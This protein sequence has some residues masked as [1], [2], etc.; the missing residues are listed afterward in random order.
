MKR[1]ST[2]APMS[3]LTALALASGQ[4]RAQRVLIHPLNATAGE[5]PEAVGL[6]HDGKTVY[7]GLI[8]SNTLVGFDAQSLN[9]VSSVSVPASTGIVSDNSGNLFTTTAPWFR[10]ILVGGGADPHQQGVWR[11]TPSG[12]ASVYG[13]LP[14]ENTLPNALAVDTTGNVYATNLV[15]DQIYRVDASGKTTLWSQ[16][17]LYA[18][19]A[20]NDPTNATPGFPLGGNGAQLRGSNL[21]TD[22]TDYGRILITPIKPDGSAGTP[23]VYLQS[24]RLIGVDAFDIDDAGNVY[25]ANLLTSELLKVTPQGVVTVLANASDGLSSPTGITLNSASDPTS[26]YFSNFSLGAF[27]FLTATGNPGIGRLDLGSSVPEPGVFAT[28]TGTAFFAGSLLLRRRKI[29]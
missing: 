22:S 23:R 15:G 1:F 20:P 16:N 18:G 8:G 12:T 13:V 7:A 4:A 26:I 6:S 21:Y 5:Y 27:P 25:G 17:A 24:D 28:M 29:G 19:K 11:V 9:S 10:N 3:F 14:F 2:L